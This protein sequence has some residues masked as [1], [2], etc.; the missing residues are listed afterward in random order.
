[1][2]PLPQNFCFTHNPILQ[3]ATW[4]ECIY[5]PLIF[6]AMAH[7]VK[8]HYQ[9]TDT[10]IQNHLWVGPGQLSLLH[11]VFAT[12]VLSSPWVPK[13]GETEKEEPVVTK[14]FATLS[15]ITTMFKDRNTTIRLQI[16]ILHHF[17]CQWTNSKKIDALSRRNGWRYMDRTRKQSAESSKLS[18]TNLLGA[19]C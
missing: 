12:H 3:F 7:V 18:E 8:N 10:W 4:T 15:L 5:Q 6:P 19:R 11:P 14:S 16:S 1:M 2:N 9:Q 13:C 17:I